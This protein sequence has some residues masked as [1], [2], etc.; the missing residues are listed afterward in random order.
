[1][2][3][4]PALVPGTL[5]S[6]HVDEASARKRA[7]RLLADMSASMAEAIFGLLGVIVGGIITGRGGVTFAAA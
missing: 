4:S 1:V 7:K 3:R 6:P 5:F 2:R